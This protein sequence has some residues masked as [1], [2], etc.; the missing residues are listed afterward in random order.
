MAS[1]PPNEFQEEN[2]S[3]SANSAP[4]TSGEDWRWI[5]RLVLVELDG[6]YPK[7]TCC[8]GISRLLERELVSPQSVFKPYVNLIKWIPP[9]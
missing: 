4:V 7:S 6:L 8:V 3:W 2:P 1:K 9:S 5:D